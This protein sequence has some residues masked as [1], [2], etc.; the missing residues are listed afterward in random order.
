MDYRADLVDAIT[1]SDLVLLGTEWREYREL[2]PQTLTPLVRTA[3]II[4]ARNVLDSQVW[5]SAG[6]TFRGLGRPT[7]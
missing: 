7:A 1:G 2:D 6:W 5:R 3:A 4:D